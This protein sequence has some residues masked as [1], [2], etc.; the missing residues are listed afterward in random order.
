MVMTQRVDQ[1]D[2]AALVGILDP[3]RDL[4]LTLISVSQPDE[5]PRGQ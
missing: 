1:T 3:I 2:Q 5:H 4:N